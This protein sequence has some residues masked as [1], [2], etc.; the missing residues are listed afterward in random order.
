MREVASI[1]ATFFVFYLSLMGF[2]ISFNSVC[3]PECDMLITFA[4]KIIVVCKYLSA[5]LADIFSP[6]MN[7]IDVSI[8]IRV[9]QFSTVAT[10][11]CRS[12]D[13]K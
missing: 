12:L 9:D 11:H 3:A 7:V 13:R 4:A 5:D 6:K 8:V 1:G 2:W 10:P